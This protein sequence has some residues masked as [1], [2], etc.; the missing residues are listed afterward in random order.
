MSANHY[1]LQFKKLCSD[2]QLGKLVSEPKAMS[3]GLL[4][5]MYAIETTQGKYAVKALNPQIMLR[6]EAI[7]NFIHSERIVSISAKNIPALPAKIINGIFLQETE[8]Q[9]YLV[10]DW[11][12][13]KTLKLNEINSDHCEQIGAILSDLHMTDF[14]ELG[15]IN[16][17]LDIGQPVDW[18]FY[19]QKGQTDNVGWVN[20]LIESLDKLYEWDA[21][22]KQ[23]AKGLASN[24]VISHR[25]LDV[26]NVMWYLDHPILID[27]ESAGY[28]NPMQD[29]IETAIYWSENE[30][31]KIDKVR[32]Y[33]FI[34]G[35]KKRYGTLQANWRMVLENGYSGKL[36]WL[37]YN[38]K[39]SL[40]LEC[41]DEEE[42][43][44]GSAQV[45]GTINALKSYA[46]I[47]PEVE[48]W[49]T[50]VTDNIN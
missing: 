11:V 42:Q 28:I 13:G 16:E 44:L 21:L 33:S 14:S 47:V 2:V 9:F 8:D 3:G 50:V 38:L 27:W 32:F 26:K 4:H 19:L 46:E 10:F 12:D 24:R 48:E 43:R 5:R 7:H 30:N 6:P 45:I 29:L 15:I 25:D 37:E 41:T 20:L 34:S 18:H 36:G 22:A 40:W 23:S 31:G 17:G 39:R 1:N 49:L 35:Y